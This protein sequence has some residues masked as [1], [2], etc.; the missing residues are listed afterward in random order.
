MSLLSLQPQM[1]E[2]ILRSHVEYLPLVGELL[3]I[4]YSDDDYHLPTL[5]EL[6]DKL[7]VS[8]GKLRKWLELLHDKLWDLISDQKEARLV[9]GEFD[10]WMT[11]SYFENH[12]Y[13]RIKMPSLPRVGDN[14]NLPFARA[15]MQGREDFFVSKIYTS[16]SGTGIKYEVLLGTGM[17]NAHEWYEDHKLFNTNIWEWKKKHRI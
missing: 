14:I 16:V 17:F 7:N 13:F 5:K 2:Y 3:E 6:Q 15:S 12:I 1:K 4:D 8:S 11:A 9:F 10:C